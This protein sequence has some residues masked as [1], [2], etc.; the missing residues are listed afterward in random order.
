MQTETAVPEQRIL[1]TG[2]LVSVSPTTIR[3]SRLV[4]LRPSARREKNL[5]FYSY[6]PNRTSGIHTG[7]SAV[8]LPG[9]DT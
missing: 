4:G 3:V 1:C 6:E 9:G 5:Q 7:T 2:K 8:D